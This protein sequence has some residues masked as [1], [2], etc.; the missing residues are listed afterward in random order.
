MEI[1]FYAFAGLCCL[2]AIGDW[3]RGVYAGIVMDVLRDPLRKLSEG[4]PV[5]IT[6]AGAVVWAF[7]AWRAWESEGRQVKAFVRSHP[8]LRTILVCLIFA[9]LPAALLSCAFYPR[10]YLLAGVGL[11]SYLGPLIGIGVGFLF[12]RS[13]EAVYRLIRFYSVINIVVL[14]GVPLEY[15][16][17]NVPGLGG[18][19]HDWIRYRS[20]YTVELIAGFYRSP[21]IMGL[22]A[23]HVIMFSA[24]LWLKKRQGANAG[25]IAAA[26]W[27]A[28]CLLLCGRRKMIGIPLV[29]FASY[30]GLCAWRRARHGQR[31]LGLAT[32]GGVVAIVAAM[33]FLDPDEVRDHTNYAST[34]FTEGPTRMNELVVGSTITTLQ[35]VGVLGAGLG[36]GTQGRYYVGVRRIRN[37]Q[38]WQEDGISRL[39]LEFGVPGAALMLFAALLAFRMTAN[40]IKA[41]PADSSLQALQI[42][43]VSAVL[44]NAASFVISH[45]QYSGDPVSAILAAMLAGMVLALTRIYYH[46]FRRS[47]LVHM[48]LLE[49]G[50]KGLLAHELSTAQAA[51]HP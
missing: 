25:W 12:A 10:G 41:I 9:L 22:H 47:R 32:M 5:S 37:N 26:V 44:G 51:E 38:G 16:E 7:V 1:L 20:G 2:M 21:D 33:F 42:G 30:I 14:S 40:A 49:E 17:W 19:Q 24:M 35:R 50:E 15:F 11:A 27:A 31:L 29:F 4:Q 45:Q 6:L 23:A 39:F 34:L 13:E 48:W 18:I 36:S 46:Q 3:R 28:F 8:Q 43:L